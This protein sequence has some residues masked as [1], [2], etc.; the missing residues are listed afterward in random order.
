MRRKTGTTSHAREAGR[1]LASNERAFDAEIVRSALSFL[2]QFYR[3]LT[4]ADLADT[5]KPFAWVPEII[6]A[7]VKDVGREV[8]P[9]QLSQ[10]ETLEECSTLTTVLRIAIPDLQ[11]LGDRNSKVDAETRDA[12]HEWLA[13]KLGGLQFSSSPVYRGRKWQM[14]TIPALFSVEHCLAYAM[15]L[16]HEDRWGFRDRI[17]L[18]PYRRKA[19]SPTHFEPDH[20][21]LDFDLDATGALKPG[22]PQRF[23]S[24]AHA[25]AYRQREWRRSQLGAG[26]PRKGK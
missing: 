20:W 9:F 22:P 10:P 19:D 13:K 21:F 15:F 4:G 16:M 26:A 1:L 8:P 14:V 23:C 12:K 25:N 7:R 11:E 17:H 18:C 5:G 6:R 24:A 3:P 2:G